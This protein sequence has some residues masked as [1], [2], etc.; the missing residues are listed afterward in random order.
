MAAR[1]ETVMTER[2]RAEEKVRAVIEEL[3]RPTLALLYKPLHDALGLAS[4]PRTSPSGN[5]AGDRWP[6]RPD[7]PATGPCLGGTGPGRIHGIARGAILIPLGDLP[8]PPARP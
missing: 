4:R 6:T 7:S 3:D 8:C 5:C 2:E 1:D